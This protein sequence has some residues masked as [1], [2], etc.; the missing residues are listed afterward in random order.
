M[1]I[2]CGDCHTGAFVADCFRYNIA[3]DNPGQDIMQ[4]LHMVKTFLRIESHG[5]GNENNNHR[6]DAV[7]K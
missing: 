6:L 5:F 4:A 1:A 7:A 3:T 2:P